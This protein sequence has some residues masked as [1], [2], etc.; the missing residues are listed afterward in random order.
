MKRRA[1]SLLETL[2]ACA[3]MG[4]AL[5]IVGQLLNAQ[6]RISRRGQEQMALQHE[7]VWLRESLRRDLFRTSGLGISLEANSLS[8]AIQPLVD[9]GP[10]GSAI[11]ATGEL[12]LYRWTSAGR[13]ERH[14]WSSQPPLTLSS[15]ALHLSP[16]DWALLAVNA[17]PRSTSWNRL[18]SIVFRS[19]SGS[20]LISQRIWVEAI[21]KTENGP[22]LL[23]LCLFTRQNT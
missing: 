2:V 22:R 21:W 12:L 20:A 5:L 4:I 23:P 9:V 11:Y 17:A 19:E 1:F 7:Q 18:E 14:H 15:P 10:D 16:A 6:L 13:L 3:L 8:L